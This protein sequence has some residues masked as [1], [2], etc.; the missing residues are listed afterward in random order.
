MRTLSD[1]AAIAGIG[2]TEF[3]KNSGRSELQLAAEAVRNALDDCGLKPSDVDGMTSFTLD[4]SDDIEVAR[5]VGI[6]DLKMFSRIPHGGGA[7]VA[8]LHQA[9]MAV[10]TGTCEAVVCY[11]A[12][13]G[14]SGQR[15]SSG[16]GEGVMTS[17][18]I[19]W[20]WYL[21][22]G[23]LTPTSWVAMFTQRYLHETGTTSLDL[24]RVA[25]ATRQY[26]ATNP[27]AWF[28]G[29][30]ITLEDHQASRLIADPLRLLDCCQES[31]GGCACIVTTPE[32]AR[33][34]R[35]PTALVRGVAQ[36][37]GADQEQMTSYYRPSIT[38]LPEMDLV[39]EQVYAA[40][41]LGPEDVDAAILYDAFTPIVL[42]QLESFGFCKRGEAKDFLRDGN[43]EI[44]GRLPTNTN[45][46]QLSEAYI[47]GMNGVNEGVRL[48][49]G[50]SVNQPRKA[51]HVLVTAGVGVPTSGMILGK[52][53]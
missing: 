45:G 46:G 36:A 31:D 32:R 12:L 1:Q 13:N 4:T 30:P 17:D 41:G 10:A 5:A 3:S 2:A 11:R 20:S 37:A 42:W 23:L 39:A 18:M 8:L 24:G 21:P 53:D 50:A 9:A 15:Y 38:R 33:D 22:Y 51:E 29:K 6:G 47:H 19:H 16:V 43:L 28:F 14:R 26:A 48:I 44:G 25:V 34:L 40:S 49:R 35:G 27:N 52:L 7:C